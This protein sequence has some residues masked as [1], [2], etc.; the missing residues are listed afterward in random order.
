MYNGPNITTRGL[1]GVIDAGSQAL[2]I[3]GNNGVLMASTG[4]EAIYIDPDTV[5]S[6]S[7]PQYFQFGADRNTYLQIS[8]LDGSFA[9]TTGPFNLPSFGGYSVEV[10]VLRTGYGTWQSGTTNYDGIWNYYWNHYLAFS[11][12][13]TGQNYIWGTG[14]SSYS[15]DMDRWYNVVMTHDNDG[16]SDNHKVYVD[17]TLQQTSTNSDPTLS[18]GNI[19]RFFV[20]NWDT[21]WSMVGRLALIRVYN[22]VLTQEEVLKNYKSTSKRFN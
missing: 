20:G 10:V 3:S 21:S 6:T 11:G 8:G 14:L 1:I 18:S 7:N 2:K 13:H 22:V 17:G 12:N 4:S 9:S 16:G 5:K 19:R 15:I